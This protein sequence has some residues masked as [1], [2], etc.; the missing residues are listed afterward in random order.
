MTELPQHIKESWIGRFVEYAQ[1]L[2]T[3]EIFKK[4]AAVSCIMGALERR[5]WVT[6]T[7]SMMFPNHYII[8]VAPPGV[9]KSRIITEV[10]S[11]WAMTGI[12]KLAPDSATKAAMVDSL[13]EAKRSFKLVD[14]TIY[15]H[16]LNIASREFGTLIHEYDNE[17]M[18][19]YNN[20]W[21]CPDNHRE[22]LRYGESK[23]VDIDFVCVNMIA[24][25]QPAYLGN[26]LPPDAF[27]MG[28][29]ARLMMVYCASAKRPPLFGPKINKDGKSKEELIKDLKR[30]ITLCGEMSYSQD[31]IT[32]L[33]DWYSQDN[34]DAPDHAR[35]AAYNVRRPMTIQKIAMA[36]SAARG[37]SLIIE[38][39]DLTFALALM[40]EAE[41]VMPEV[42]K[43]MN[44]P[45]SSEV[46]AELYNYCIVRYTRSGRKPLPENM[47]I[48]FLRQKVEVHKIDPIMKHMQT[49]GLLREAPGSEIL[50]GKF[51]VLGKRFIPGVKD[52]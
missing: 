30:V 10:H 27:G 23:N 18:N 39:E 51:L 29:T 7:D 40:L 21:D 48:D 16:S 8:L 25:T 3:P 9:G 50:D 6:T 32:F 37:N 35:L 12:L 36:A 28:F 22:R 5:V 38:K 41:D 19:F 24:G 45:E 49:S 26:L 17:T 13:N 20:I 34:S 31:A 47:L 14:E 33:E 4:W 46:M 44:T 15:M 1:P 52:I 2:P 42:F 11:L 43:G